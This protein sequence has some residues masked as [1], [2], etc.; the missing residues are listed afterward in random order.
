M[1]VVLTGIII[2]STPFR[3]PL[4]PHPPTHGTY[5]PPWSN[6]TFTTWSTAT[7]PAT[8]GAAK[9]VPVA[10]VCTNFPPVP[11]PTTCT[12]FG[13]SPPGAEKASVSPQLL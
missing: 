7:T 10:V 1:W 4:T 12:G 11:T 13:P 8:C 5:F 2:G 9:L 6:D 3:I